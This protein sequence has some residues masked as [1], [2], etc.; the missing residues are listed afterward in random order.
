MKAQVLEI[1]EQNPKR[2]VSGSEI[3]RQLGVTRAA[4]WKAVQ[5]LREEGYQI[6]SVSNRGYRLAPQNDRLSPP[7]IR[8]AY[9]GGLFGDIQVFAQLDSTNN[10]AKE[11]ARQ[12]A[13]EGTVVLAEEQSAGKGRMGRR[14]Y[15]PGG[16]GIYLSAVLRP[17]LPAE[18]AALL[19]VLASVAVARAVEALCP[20]RVGI[21]WVNDLFVEGKKICG[22]LTEAAMEMESGQLEYAVL[23]IGV[24]VRLGE[25]P[26]ELV[27]IVGAVGHDVKRN[28][29]TAKIL[30]EL[31]GLYPQL[32]QRSFLE[33]YR[34]RSIV[35]GRSVQVVQGEE[36]TAAVA[37][38][39]DD[40]ARLVV[41]LPDG[42]R[43]TL[44]SGEISIRL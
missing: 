39:I 8:Q 25:L 31:E 22:I 24:N 1:L 3:G 28:A 12:G 10:K 21:K 38:A 23:G 44:N 15:S 32:A 27:P 26:P 16:A 34:A 9:H 19:T 7:G 5:Q 43:K 37:L 6:E 17:H 35:L 42:S 11:L 2:S 41:Q 40:E 14:F 36:Q 20:L 33:E 4:V 29:L 13:P 30:E 18:S